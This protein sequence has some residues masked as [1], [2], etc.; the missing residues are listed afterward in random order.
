MSFSFLLASWGTSGN[1]SPLL[2]AGRRLRR[3]GHQVRV[4]ADP[5][6]REEVERDGFPFATWRRAP[7]GTHADPMDVTDLRDFFRRVIF[8]PL[9]LYAADIR[10]EIETLPIDAVLSIDCLFGAAL[11]AE[12]ARV[13]FAMLSPHVSARPLAGVPPIGSGLRPP[14]TSQERAEVDAANNRF[15]D[16]LN[17]FLPDINQARASLDLE[18]FAHVLDIYDRADRVLLGISQAF[19]FDADYL[20]ENTRYIGPLLDEPGWSKPWEGSWPRGSKSPRA[21]ISFS[22]GAQGQADVVQRV[23]SAMSKVEVDAV[24]TAGPSLDVTHLKPSKNVR[25]FVSAPHDA[26][27]SEVS[28][29][30]SHGGHGTV[31]RALIHGLPQLI[32]PNGRDQT[33]NA[34]RVEARG[35]GL[36]LPGTAPEEDIAAA[37]N[38]LIREPHFRVAARR[39]GDAMATDCH[40]SIL[41]QEMESIAAAR[42]EVSEPYPRVLC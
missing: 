8:N 12:A 42:R 24:L 17:E 30:V 13:G 39:L 25:V 10:D 1:L 40:S 32:M 29:I 38:R 35:A 16:L 34:L 11:G 15:A 2:T 6:M 19:D 9:F 22:T 36:V 14:K 23:V 5:A 18:P 41:V 27:M 3:A 4:I 31:S 21:L 7:V 33:D 37:I 20:P 28:L 26:V